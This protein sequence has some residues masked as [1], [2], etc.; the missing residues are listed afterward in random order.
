MSGE[1]AA[2]RLFVALWPDAALVAALQAEQARWRWPSGAT[3]TPPDKLHLTLHFLGAVADAPARALAGRL[4]RRSAPIALVLDRRECW[5]NGCAVL[6][7]G[8]TPD[9]LLALHARVAA[10]LHRLGLEPEARAWR[11]HLTLARRAQGAVP[12]PA[13]TPPL[14]WAAARVVLVRSQAGRYSVLAPR[15]GAQ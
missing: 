8:R 9:A 15:G 13:E 14:H 7:P 11:A 2:Q 10:L 12:P 1:G 3:P 5:S 4:P 6:T